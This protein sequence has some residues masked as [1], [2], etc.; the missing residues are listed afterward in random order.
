MKTARALLV[1]KDP[2]V[3]NRLLSA[4]RANGHAVEGT[5]SWETAHED[6][7]A[8]DFTLIGLGGGF[9]DQERA[10]LRQG[11]QLQNPET[12]LADVFGPVGHAQL[13]FLLSPAA[14]QPA[15]EHLTV[16][17][18]ELPPQVQLIVRTQTEATIT[19]YHFQGQLHTEEVWK[20]ELP[21]G[22][23]Q[24]PLQREQLLPDMLYHVVAQ[25]PEGEV[26]THRFTLP[27]VE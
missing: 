23:T 11:F 16:S 14:Q 2:L 12:R 5:V 13:Q 1:G 3:M 18:T 22:T 17:L 21:A 15:L 19:L 25:L 10:Q 27:R 6:F 9:N 24:L 20:G 7:N 4:L 26:H 8:H